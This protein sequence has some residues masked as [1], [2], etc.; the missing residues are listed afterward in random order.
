MLAISVR[1]PLVCRLL[2]E[3]GVVMIDWSGIRT[4][5]LGD[6]CSKDG[7][8]KVQLPILPA[9]VMEFSQK[10]VILTATS[11]SCQRSSMAL[12]AN[13]CETP[14]QVPTG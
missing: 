5:V 4:S 2:I 12:P 11:R 14:M 10:A 8:P 3:R 7:I 1:I 6:E 9:A 13:Y